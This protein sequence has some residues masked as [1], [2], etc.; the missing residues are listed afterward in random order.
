[1]K[2]FGI[3]PPIS[4]APP[5]AHDRK[6]TDDMD[7]VLRDENLYE[8]AEEAQKREDVLGKLNLIVREW[9]RQVSIKKVKVDT[10]AWYLI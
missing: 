6:I 2:Q 8:S 1:M 5:T 7:K 4:T 10:I 3:T 9:V